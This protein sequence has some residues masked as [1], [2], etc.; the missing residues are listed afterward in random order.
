MQ[1][2]FGMYVEEEETGRSGTSINFEE[3]AEEA[4]EEEEEEEAEEAKEA[5]ADGSINASGSF[6]AFRADC[7][8]LSFSRLLL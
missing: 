8:F 3:E 1:L 5:E 4:E 2:F 6:L 7:S